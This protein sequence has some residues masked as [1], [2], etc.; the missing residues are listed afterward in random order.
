M[1]PVRAR[2]VGRC[3]AVPECRKG[4]IST[5]ITRRERGVI[6]MRLKFKF[7]LLWKVKSNRNS[8]FEFANFEGQ[9]LKAS[10]INIG[11]ETIPL[12]TS[13]HHEITAKES[14][15]ASVQF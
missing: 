2:G 5:G 7:K 1:P 11:F 8:L 9:T 15:Q 6:V 10:A 14:A 12:K 4:S 13:N 3:L